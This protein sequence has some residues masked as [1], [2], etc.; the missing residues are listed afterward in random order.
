MV[1]LSLSVK[2]RT[3]LNKLIDSIKKVEGVQ[4]V[5]RVNTM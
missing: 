3:Q 4:K 2:N 5:E 1:K